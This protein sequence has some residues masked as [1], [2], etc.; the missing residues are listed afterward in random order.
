[1]HL[2][3]NRT[4]TDGIVSVTRACPPPGQILG[5]HCWWGWTMKW[6]ATVRRSAPPLV[7][8]WLMNWRCANRHSFP[9]SF[10]PASHL[11]LFLWLTFSLSSPSFPFA[12]PLR[13][14]PRCYYIYSFLR[15]NSS[16]ECSWLPPP[17]LSF[18][19]VSTGNCHFSYFSFLT[20]HFFTMHP[21]PLAFTP[22]RCVAYLW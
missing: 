22:S 20:D 9:L 11:S 3:W 13:P 6:L 8:V 17:L 19:I 12:L 21:C 14:S 16:G 15:Y 5:K 2:R 18:I 1:M 4:A 10:S 7:V